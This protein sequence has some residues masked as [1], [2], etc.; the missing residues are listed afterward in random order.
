A[1]RHGERPANS[2]INAAA[3]AEDGE[4]APS[5]VAEDA[6]AGECEPSVIKDAAPSV[7]V[8]RMA[9][10][11]GETGDGDVRGEI[12]EHPGSGVAVDRQISSTGAVNGHVVGNL[13][14]SA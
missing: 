4:K 3:K 10:G 12:F 14:F 5:I 11:Y 7:F 13:K 6:S 9:V 8:G 2:T 1:V